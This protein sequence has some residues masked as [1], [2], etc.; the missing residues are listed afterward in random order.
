[1]ELGEKR[2]HMGKFANLGFKDTLGRHWKSG[3][4]KTDFFQYFIL[5]L[6]SIQLSAISCQDH[7]RQLGF[8]ELA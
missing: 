8:E 2:P 7:L 4:G 5:K 6:M 1:M 3:S